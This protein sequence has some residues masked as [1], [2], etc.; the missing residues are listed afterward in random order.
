MQ[1]LEAKSWIEM[2]VMSKY[3]F[4]QIFNILFI[5][6]VQSAVSSFVAFP[7]T[8]LK[9]VIETLGKILPKVKRI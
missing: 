9:D 7:T 4:Y 5:G 2:S 6:F 1:G 3:F 8:T